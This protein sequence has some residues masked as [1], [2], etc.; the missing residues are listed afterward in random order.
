MKEIKKRGRHMNKQISDNTL[1]PLTDQGHSINAEIYKEKNQF[2]ARFNLKRLSYFIH[3]SYIPA[4]VGT[5]IGLEMRNLQ[6]CETLYDRLNID[7]YH[8]KRCVA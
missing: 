2:E 8:P 4:F 6:L 7:Q 1:H 5:C 3:G